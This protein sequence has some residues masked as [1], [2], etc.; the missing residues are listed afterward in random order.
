MQPLPTEYAPFY[1][2]YIE[3][4]QGQ[5]IPE[6]LTTQLEE[7][8]LAFGGL[9]EQQGSF[10]YA[11]GKWNIKEMLGHLNDTERVFAYRALCI[12]RGDQTPLPGFEQDDFMRFADFGQRPLARLLEEFHLLRR[13]SLMLLEGC[14]PEDLKRMGTASDA[15]VSVRALFAMMSGHVAHHLHVFQTRY[16]PKL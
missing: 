4:L 6:V 12:A 11:E 14:S 7:L 10:R 1:A 9:S 5:S 16:R 13:S 2:G 8:P 15:P 3:Q